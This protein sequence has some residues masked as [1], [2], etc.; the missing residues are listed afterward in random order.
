VASL[1]LY[2]SGDGVYSDASMEQYARVFIM[3]GGDAEF[4][5]YQ[6]KGANGHLLFKRGLPLWERDVENFLK[7]TG[8]LPA[9]PAGVTAAPP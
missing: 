5:L 6:M 2:A 8:M 3:A 9:Q 1:F 4:R 7:K